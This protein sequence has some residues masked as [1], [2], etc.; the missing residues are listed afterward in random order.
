LGLAK[1]AKTLTKRQTSLALSYLDQTRYPDRNRAIFLLSIK[2]G[3]RAKEIAALTWDMITDAEGELGT[4]IHLQN[5]AS[6]GNS[7]RIIPLNSELRS[8]LQ[9]L[10]VTKK[11]SEFV[12]TSERSSRTSAAVIVNLFAG[13]YCVLNYSGCSSHTGRRTFITNAARQISGVGG[14]LRDVQNLAGHA[15]LST[16]QLYIECHADAQ[17]RVVDLI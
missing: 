8:A 3:L 13:W 1:Q 6:K 5:V 16:T 10:F 7:G 17:Q 2:A 15:T 11:K 9:L 14:S 12:I 4:A